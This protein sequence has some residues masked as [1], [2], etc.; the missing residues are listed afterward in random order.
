MLQNDVEEPFL[1]INQHFSGL[2]A[3]RGESRSVVKQYRR[4]LI[5]EAQL[6]SGRRECDKIRQK[7]QRKGVQVF[8]VSSARYLD[9]LDPSPLEDPPFDAQGTGIPAL[10]RALLMLPAEA[11]CKDLR[12]H[13]FETVA[14]VED[15]AVSYTHLT[16]PTKRIV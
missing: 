8:P 5:R 10:R 7:M 11:N 12:Y 6:A 3:L 2:K 13:I 14:D 4:Y 1:T 16:L 9:W 15:K